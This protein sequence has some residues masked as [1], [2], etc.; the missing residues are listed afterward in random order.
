M[1]VVVFGKR[2]AFF[3]GCAVLNQANQ[4]LAGDVVAVKGGG[5]VG[6]L[7]VGG[8]QCHVERFE[9]GFGLWLLGEQGGKV[10]GQQDAAVY[11]GL[12]VGDDGLGGGAGDGDGFGVE[13]E[14][15]G[16]EIVLD[17]VQGGVG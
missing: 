4:A 3:Y 6:V 8:V 10:A 12:P 7:A 16:L 5:L 9:Q 14:G 15:L 1:P 17:G 11:V 13:R 2:D